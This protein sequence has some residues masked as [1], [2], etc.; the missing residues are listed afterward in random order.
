MNWPTSA[1]RLASVS[2]LGITLLGLTSGCEKAT[3]LGLEL[4]G[5]S[6]IS[7]TYLDLSV[8][9]STVRQPVVQT[10]KANSALVGRI[11]DSFVGTTTAAAALNLLVLPALSPLDSLPAKFTDARLDSAVFSLTF[12]QVYGSATQPLVLDVLPLKQALDER[13][14]YN[15]TT[16][17]ETNAPLVSSFAAV[18][19]RDNIIQLPTSNSPDVITVASPQRTIRIPLLKPGGTAP[20]V[21]SV[22]AAM[23][24]NAAFNQSTLDGLWKG[25]LLQPSASHS[26]NIIGIPRAASRTINVIT[27]Y[28]RTGTEGKRRSYSIYL[29]N[30]APPTQAGSFTDGRYF[31]QLTTDFTGGALAGLTPQNPLTAARTNGLTYVQEG[32]GLNTRLEFTGPELDSLRN[33]PTL[34]INRA[35]LLIPVRQLSNGL[36][37]YPSALYLYEVNDTNQILTRQSG[38]S[39]IDRLVQQDEPVQLSS[40]ALVLPS[41]TGVGYPAPVLVPFGQNPTQF[42]TVSITKYLQVF[43]QNRF[44]TGEDRPSGL[45]LSPALRNSEGLLLPQQSGTVAN[46]NLNRAQLDAN[47]I[48]L[49]V[50]YSKL[51]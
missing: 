20:L 2:L 14:V 38:A 36:F 39:T 27:F 22:F 42:Y 48:R 23:T 40:G 31:T 41:S 30:I 11:R 6:P 29:A 26:G 1:G 33:N 46:L 32:T 3:D 12:D 37:P 15:S 18:L 35:E 34:V 7:A 24:S 21:S 43:L 25:V 4:P 5:T 50:Y 17:V 44:N 8:K 13:T 47:N 10:V 51:Q 28:F 45:L 16:A 49:R 19:N 9:A